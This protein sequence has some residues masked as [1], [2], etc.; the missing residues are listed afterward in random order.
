MGCDRVKKVIFISCIKDR[1]KWFPG[2]TER[3]KFLET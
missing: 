2:G 3:I 1:N